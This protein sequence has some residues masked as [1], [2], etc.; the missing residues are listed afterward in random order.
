MLNRASRTAQGTALHRAAHQLFD[1]PLI[2]EDPLAVKLLEARESARLSLASARLA[3]TRSANSRAFV[4]VR[5]RFA[6]DRLRE[7]VTR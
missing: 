2:F 5:S 3:N 6:E 7:A 1:R 4:V